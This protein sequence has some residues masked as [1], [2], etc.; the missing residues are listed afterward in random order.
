MNEVNVPE[1]EDCGHKKYKMLITE[2]S[3]F[4][5]LLHRTYDENNI[6]KINSSCH[7]KDSSNQLNNKIAKD[8]NV[9][10]III[11]F[12]CKLLGCKQNKVQKE[13]LVGYIIKPVHSNSS[14]TS[15]LDSKMLTFFPVWLIEDEYGY[16]ELLENGVDFEFTYLSTYQEDEY[17]E[18][19][20]VIADQLPQAQKDFDHNTLQYYKKEFFNKSFLSRHD[21][22]LIT[23]YSEYIGISGAKLSSGNFL[24][25]YYSDD[26]NKNTVLCNVDYFT[27]RLMGLCVKDK[28]DDKLIFTSANQKKCGCDSSLLKTDDNTRT[29]S[30]K[31]DNDDPNHSTQ[32]S[33]HT[34]PCPPSWRPQP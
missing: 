15:E 18:G 32:T 5:S 34:N 9:K 31:S 8:I 24:S 21:L 27:Y 7:Y 16:K 22:F 26:F 6:L 11:K 1:K 25:Y 33:V 10:N 19:V 2:S 30:L 17:P 3:F 13:T 14:G 28:Q 12:L 29:A 20:H 23:T 4:S